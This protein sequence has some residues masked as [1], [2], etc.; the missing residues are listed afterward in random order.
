MGFTR[1]DLK[2]QIVKTSLWPSWT[3]NALWF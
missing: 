2:I 3:N 1:C